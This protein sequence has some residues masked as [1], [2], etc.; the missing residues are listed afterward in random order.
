VGV[1]V[2]VRPVGHRETMRAVVWQGAGDIRVE[3]VPD[4]RIEEGTDVVIRVT[5]TGLCGSDLHLYE[6][7]PLDQAPDAYETFQKKQD[8]AVKIVFR[9]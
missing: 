7:L 3:H 2:D 6:V 1:G 9:P 5:S 8:G 4:P